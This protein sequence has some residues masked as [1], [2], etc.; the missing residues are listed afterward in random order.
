MVLVSIF[1]LIATVVY[2]AAFFYALIF[3]GAEATEWFKTLVP[4]WF[5]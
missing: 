3:L 1:W 2:F 4:G 5:S